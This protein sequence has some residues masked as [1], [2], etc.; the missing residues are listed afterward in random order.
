[1]VFHT[2][3]RSIQLRLLEKLR[4]HGTDIAAEVYKGMNVGT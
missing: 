4:A 3:P 2:R 1:V